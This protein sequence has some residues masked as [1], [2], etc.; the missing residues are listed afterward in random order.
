MLKYGMRGHK[1]MWLAS[2]RMEA[3]EDA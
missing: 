3:W 2:R 1:E